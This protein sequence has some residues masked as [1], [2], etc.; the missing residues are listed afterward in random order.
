MEH[1]TCLMEICVRDLFFVCCYVVLLFEK[2]DVHCDRMCALLFWIVI[3]SYGFF[4]FFF[5]SSILFLS[6]FW[7]CRRR[8]LTMSMNPRQHQRWN[9]ILCRRN[10]CS[11]KMLP[12]RQNMYF[13]YSVALYLSLSTNGARCHIWNY[14]WSQPNTFLQ[15]NNIIMILLE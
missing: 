1:E 2:K 9:N 12:Q 15:Y 5:C 10:Y 4:L 7:Q 11:P 3:I 13:V 14:V 8:T 6:I